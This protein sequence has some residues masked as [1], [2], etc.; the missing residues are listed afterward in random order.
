M[1][2]HHQLFSSVMGHCQREKVSVS[3]LGFPLKN[4]NGMF[5]LLKQVF[6]SE[7]AI[8]IDAWLEV[9]ITGE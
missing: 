5:N 7:I 9:P 2:R 6:R 8:M 3:S 4:V 1:I